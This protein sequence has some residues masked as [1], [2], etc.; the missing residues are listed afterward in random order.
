MKESTDDQ[1]TAGSSCSCCGERD[2]S[3]SGI[4]KLTICPECGSSGKKVGN[5][6]LESLLLTEHLSIISGDVWRFCSSEN[7]RVVYFSERSGEILNTETLKVP[8]HQK[9]QEDLY[10]PVCYC[11]GHS[12]ASIAL[13]IEETGKSTVIENI[14]AMMKNP[15]CHCEDANPQGSCCMGNVKSVVQ[16]IINC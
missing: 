10:V 13:E 14:K 4:K 11:F 7:C 6:T 5:I 2:E 16:D 3:Q 15:G 12:P 9:S 8:V 1:N